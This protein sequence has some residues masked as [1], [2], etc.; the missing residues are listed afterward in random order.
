MKKFTLILLCFGLNF[1]LQA[2]DDSEVFN[3]KGR[4]LVETGYNLVAGFSSGTGLSLFVDEEGNTVTSVGFD[5]G[6]FISENFALKMKLSL[7]SSLGSITNFQA[8]G[9]Y[10]IGGRVPFELSAG[11]LSGGD[12]SEFLAN[13]SIGYAI[14]LAENITLEPNIGGL[15][16]GDGILLEF[17]MSFSMFL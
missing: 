15:G 16:T 8:G 17:G 4:V 11:L 2:Q 5:G 7:L 1:G 3:R 10:Y 14:N 12:N 6:Y 9:K 13:L